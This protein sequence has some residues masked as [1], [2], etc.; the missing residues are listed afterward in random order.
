VLAFTTTRDC[1]VAS[2]LLRPTPSP[3]VSQRAQKSVERP[4]P[5]LPAEIGTV[6][7]R[8]PK[9]ESDVNAGVANL[10]GHRLKAVVAADNSRR[11]GRRGRAE[12]H[13]AAKETGEDLGGRG[14]DCGVSGRVL[15]ME[16]GRA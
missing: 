14:A 7:D 3:I 11:A 8:G 16:R 10:V 5:D 12:R 9:M 1:P 4:V 2:A 13:V 6:A 15:R